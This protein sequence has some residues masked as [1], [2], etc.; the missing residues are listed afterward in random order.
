MENSAICK[1]PWC[2][3]RFEYV[4]DNIPDQCPKCRSFDN[5]LSGGVTW[6]DKRYDG[7]RYDPSPHHIDIKIQRSGDKEKKW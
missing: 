4:G 5:E 7:V 6:V 3:V 1:S 2:R